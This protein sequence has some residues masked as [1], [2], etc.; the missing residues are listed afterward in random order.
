MGPPCFF[1]LEMLQLHEQSLVVID[2]FK[3]NHSH[4]LP[5]E[6]K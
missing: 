4:N 1:T 3:E 2:Y 6:V 5:V